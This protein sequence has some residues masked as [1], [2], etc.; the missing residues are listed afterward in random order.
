[1]SGFHCSAVIAR[2]VPNSPVKLVHK[3]KQSFA[4]GTARGFLLAPQDQR[5]AALQN[6]QF[7][8]KQTEP[9]SAVILGRRTLLDSWFQVKLRYSKMLFVT[10]GRQLSLQELPS[11][12]KSIP[13]GV[14]RFGEKTDLLDKCCITQHN[15][16]IF[17]LQDPLCFGSRILWSSPFVSSDVYLVDSLISG[18]LGTS[19]G[20]PCP[21]NDGASSCETQYLVTTT[22]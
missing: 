17:C 18:S 19:S 15:I 3:F 2:L 10:A 1:M 11:T 9:N 8:F 7:G 22:R 4:F 14:C 5:R 16:K 21:H 6:R 12:N 20:S 13:A